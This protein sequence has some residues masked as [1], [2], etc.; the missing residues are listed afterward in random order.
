MRAG[1][2]TDIMEAVGALRNFA[3]APKIEYTAK[4]KIALKSEYNA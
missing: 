1:G 4:L 3:K 2:R